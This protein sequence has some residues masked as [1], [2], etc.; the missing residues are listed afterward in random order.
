MT[1]RPLHPAR[2]AVNYNA[3]VVLPPIASDARDADTCA[4][5]TFSMG[6]TFQR[7]KVKASRRARGQVEVDFLIDSGAVYSLVPA[8]QLRRLKIIPYKTLGF[9][10]ADGTVVSRRVGDAYFEFDRRC[11]AGHLRKER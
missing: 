1:G 10:L 6:L 8:R 2:L 7:L 9:T 3:A 11:G 4:G 5:Y